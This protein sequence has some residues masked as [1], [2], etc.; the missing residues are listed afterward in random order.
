MIRRLART[1]HKLAQCQHGGMALETVFIAPVLITLSLGGFEVS[2]IV[3]RQTELQSAAAEVA[4]VVRASVP[5]TSED[6]TTIRD[7]VVESAGVTNEDVSVVEVY[8]CGTGST[9]SD[10][11]PTCSTGAVLS[12]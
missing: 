5:E 9:Y 4:S 1:I 7:I 3:A 8:R 12:K 6:R 11:L 2:K 10:T